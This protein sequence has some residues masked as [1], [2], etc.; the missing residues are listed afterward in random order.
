M[1]TRWVIC[2]DGTW[3]EPEQTDAG[4]PCPSNVVRLA[5]AVASR[6]ADGTPQVVCYHSGVGARGGLLDHIQGGA[7]GDGISLNIRDLYL[8]LVLNYRP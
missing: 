8:F 4:M 1:A 2:A 5:K 6:G 3:N 7:F